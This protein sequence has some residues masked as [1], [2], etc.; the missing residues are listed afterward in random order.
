[1]AKF[2]PKTRNEL[3][4]LVDDVKI[5]LGDI[6]TSLITDMSR[7]FYYTKRQDFSGIELWDVSNVYNMSFMFGV[8]VCESAT[9]E[10]NQ[11]LNSWDISNVTNMSE[12]F[13]EASSLDQPLNAWNVSCVANMSFMFGCDKFTPE[14]LV[15]KFNQSLDKQDQ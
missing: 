4:A 2:K 13:F 3:R 6:D 1:M 14:Y 15:E 11:F 10:F 5:N 8:R 12:I 9:I 7:L